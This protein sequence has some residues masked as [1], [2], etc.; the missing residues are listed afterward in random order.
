MWARR[1]GSWDERTR[2]RWAPKSGGGQRWNGLGELRQHRVE[3]KALSAIRIRDLVSVVAFDDGHDDLQLIPAGESDERLDP[4]EARHLPAHP[5]SVG[6]GGCA[7]SLGR[8]A[9]G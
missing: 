1:A 6:G 4:F 2:W 5:L 3:Q 8:L 7:Q 9:L